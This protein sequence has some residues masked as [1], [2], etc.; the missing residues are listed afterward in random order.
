MAKFIIAYSDNYLRHF[1][2]FLR[3]V[4]LGSVN[5]TPFFSLYLFLLSQT[6]PLTAAEPAVTISCLQCSHGCTDNCH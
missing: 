4:R 3:E 5:F 2:E 6:V 1:C